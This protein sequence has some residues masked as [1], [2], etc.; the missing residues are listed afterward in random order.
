MEQISVETLKER[1]DSG[2]DVHLLDVRE[3]NEREAFNIGGRHV[4]LGRIQMFDLDD[5]EDWKDTE[6]VVYCRSGKRSALATMML[7]QAGFNQVLNLDGGM[8]KWQET[9]G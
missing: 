5:L 4:A 3:D 7:G 1:M 9:Y 2:Q 8:L 6:I